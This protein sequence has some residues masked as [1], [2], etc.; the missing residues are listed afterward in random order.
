M[1]NTG[2]TERAYEADKRQRAEGALAA[3][4][5]PRSSGEAEDAASAAA[6]QQRHEMIAMG[7]YFLAEARGFVAGCELDDWL[8]AEAEIDARLQQTQHRS[9]TSAE[10]AESEHEGGN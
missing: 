8:R 4:Y 1:A 10:R 5:P 7:A 6:T 3:P 9:A 2:T